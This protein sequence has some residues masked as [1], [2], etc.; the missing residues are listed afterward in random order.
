MV[1]SPIYFVILI[2]ISISTVIDGRIFISIRIGIAITVDIPRRSAISI[3]IDIPIDIYR[4]RVWYF[5]IIY[6]PIS[7]K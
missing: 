1:Q 4:Y 2:I 7:F 5:S 6:G 3:F